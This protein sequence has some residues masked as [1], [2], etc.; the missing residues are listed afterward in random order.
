MKNL[1][2]LPAT[3]LLFFGIDRGMGYL[4]QKTTDSSQFRYSRMYR[5][6]A[7]AEIL[8]LGNSRGL[9][10]FQP[11][12]EEK[13]G[14]TTFN[15]SY[16]G[17][18]MDLANVLVTDYLEKY[19]A[20][21]SFVI[22]IT[23]LDRRNESLAVGFSPYLE[24]SPNISNFIKKMK[25]EMW[26]GNQISHLFRF[27]N[28][29]FQRAFYHRNTTDAAWLLDREITPQ[30]VAGMERDSYNLKIDT[31]LVE[32]LAE[33][34][35]F[36]AQKGVPVH[37]VIAPYFPNFADNVGN[38]DKLKNICEAKTGLK[39]HDYR[40]SIAD[41]TCFGDFMHPNKKGAAV[42]IDLMRADGVL[43]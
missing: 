36:A 30:L 37:L 28:E 3:L 9:T 18:P 34:T 2:W 21:K 26:W 1:L 38:L 32:K 39:V 42:F 23:M 25:P 22:D 15:L 13:S 11:T 10:F 6:D 27:N 4:L 7:A 5:G 29:V 33:T 35:R 14:K 17:L 41:P 43:P 20:P 24:K 8:L 40:Q 12:I 16:N 31:F 19:P